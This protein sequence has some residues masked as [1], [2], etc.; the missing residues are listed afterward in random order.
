MTRLTQSMRDTIERR[1]LDHRF[2]AEE[3][4]IKE[5][6]AALGEAV[7]RDLYPK[8]VLDQMEAL[9]NGWLPESQ[10]ISVRFGDG[11]GNYQGFRF[12]Q[13][14][15][16]QERHEGTAKVYDEKA[17]LAKRYAALKDREAAL[18]SDT[19]EASKKARAVLNSVTTL[20]RLVEVWPEV[21]PFVKGLGDDGSKGVPAVPIKELNET[22]NLKRAA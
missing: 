11:I 16:L 22:L 12:E 2:A 20:K 14:R 5:E 8:K 4:A 18:K 10:S 3:K 9:P 15:R 19:Q 21:A 6:R 17:P 1:L 7:Y 13:S